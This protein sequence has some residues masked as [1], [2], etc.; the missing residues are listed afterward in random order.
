MANY[1]NHEALPTQ[2]CQC[3][4]LEAG[5]FTSGPTAKNPNEVY[6][7]C[8]IDKRAR[9]TGCKHFRFQ[10]AEL[11]KRPQGG[12]GGGFGGSTQG[13]GYAGRGRGYSAPA[14]PYQSAPSG[15]SY[16][17]YATA[18]APQQL[19]QPQQQV[20]TNK[21]QRTEESTEQLQAQ[22]SELSEGIAFLLEMVRDIKDCVDE[23]SANQKELTKVVVRQLKGK[24]RA[25]EMDV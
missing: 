25:E 24:E 3:G 20:D 2:L 17:Q 8:A 15:P 12:R 1:Y 16:S 10:R 9:G 5:P 6:F 13:G 21:R 11:N 18:P 14:Q 4:Q 23:L 7:S 19:P 22:Q